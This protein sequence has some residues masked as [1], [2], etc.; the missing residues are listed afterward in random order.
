VQ[1]QNV[2]LDLY[3]SDTLGNRETN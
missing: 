1:A 2:I 3:S